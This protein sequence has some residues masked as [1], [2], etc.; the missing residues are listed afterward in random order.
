MIPS[1]DIIFI[2]GDNHVLTAVHYD[3]QK[4]NKK[5]YFKY[6]SKKYYIC[7]TAG[8]GRRLFGEKSLKRSKYELFPL[9]IQ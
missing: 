3:E 9:T 8:P 5:N 6:N 4:I 1:N 7:E 2:K